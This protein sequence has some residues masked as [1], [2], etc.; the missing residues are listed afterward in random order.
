VIGILPVPAEDARLPTSGSACRRAGACLRGRGSFAAEIRGAEEGR[1]RATAGGGPP[2]A[3][4]GRGPGPQGQ[5]R[6]VLETLVRVWWN[7]R[8]PMRGAR[9]FSV[10]NVSA[11]IDDQ[12]SLKEGEQ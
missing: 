7:R 12:K 1:G 9:R 2:V 5:G 6:W 4:T 3:Q 10:R 8:L 11:A